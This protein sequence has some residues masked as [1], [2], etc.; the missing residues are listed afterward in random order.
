[1]RSADRRARSQRHGVET[2]T[3]QK[4]AFVVT[5]GWI[6]MFAGYFFGCG[7]YRLLGIASKSW[8]FGHD[9]L[10]REMRTWIAFT[11]AG[12]LCLLPYFMSKE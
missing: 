1:M 7:C 2:M 10:A 4:W 5:A 12:L 9:E 3:K 8:E 6:F 11:V